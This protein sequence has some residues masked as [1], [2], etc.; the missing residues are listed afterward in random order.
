MRGEGKRTLQSLSS[1]RR[2]HLEWQISCVVSNDNSTVARLTRGF[3][4]VRWEGNSP[5]LFRLPWRSRRKSPFPIQGA[6]E[7]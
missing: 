4:S 7:A 6:P 2:H 1:E 3:V 5:V